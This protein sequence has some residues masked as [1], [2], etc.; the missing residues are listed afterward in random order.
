[1]VLDCASIPQV[2]CVHDVRVCTYNGLSQCHD[3]A[4]GISCMEKRTGLLLWSYKRLQSI[5]L[6]EQGSKRGMCTCLLNW[7]VG[8]C[9]APEVTKSVYFMAVL[10]LLDIS[11]EQQQLV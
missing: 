4:D 11:T 5:Y 7:P 6:A 10:L 9:A 8:L 2:V 1:M 3:F